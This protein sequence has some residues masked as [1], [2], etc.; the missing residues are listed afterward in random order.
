MVVYLG[1][2]I[3]KNYV[4]CARDI[5][6][7]AGLIISCARHYIYRVHETSSRAQD[8]ISRAH[9]VSRAHD[10]ISIYTCQYQEWRSFTDNFLF[11]RALTLV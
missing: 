6:S 9:G 10:I 7:R 5:I 8:I 1:H 4:V 2:A 3:L 11:V